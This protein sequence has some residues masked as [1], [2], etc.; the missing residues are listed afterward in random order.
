MK[1]E[2]DPNVYRKI[3]SFQVNEIV[4]VENRNGARTTIHVENITKLTWRELQLLMPEGIDK[5]SK[6]VL[7][8]ERYRNSTPEAGHQVNGKKLSHQET[9][10]VNAYVKIYRDNGFTMHFQVNEYISGNNLW[11]KF[12]N[13]RSL[14][15]H[16]EFTEI[17]GIQPKYFEIACQLPGITGG[18]GRPL[19]AFRKY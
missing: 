14:N 8:Y 3:A 6:M 2:Y 15:D 12:P 13:I 18:D 19:D 4:Q 7:L 1:T 9:E 16:G 10:E 5:F 11:A 17:P